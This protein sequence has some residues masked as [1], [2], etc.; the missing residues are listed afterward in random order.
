MLH[1]HTLRAETPDGA[2]QLC[3][4]NNACSVH[5]QMSCV[6][7][8]TSYAGSWTLTLW[9]DLILSRT[10]GI[11]LHYSRGMEHIRDDVN[12]S[13]FIHFNLGTGSVGGRQMGRDYVLKAGGGGVFVHNEPVAVGLYNGAD[14]LGLALPREATRRWTVAPEDVSGR[15]LA[16]DGFAFGMLRQYLEV[17]SRSELTPGEGAI[18]RSH[19]ADLAGLWLGGLRDEGHDRIAPTRQ[20]ARALSIRDYV[21]RHFSDPD[22]SLVSMARALG[23]SAR[24]AQQVLQA[25]G[26]HFSR[27]V[28]EARLNAAA[29]RLG[30]PRVRDQS[31]TEIAFA[32]GFNDLSAFYKAFSARFDMAPGRYRAYRE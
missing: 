7:A 18:A 3:A 6:D 2:R 21:A 9:D 8:E 12:D 14:I 31:V 17:L 10:Q 26:T 29:R 23:L 13:V 15:D 27:L 32:C 1:R 20:A 16:T 19:M 28:A 11:G 4:L 25:E 24:L 5:S 30:D 22:L